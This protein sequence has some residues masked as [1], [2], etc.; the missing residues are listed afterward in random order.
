MNPEAINSVIDNLASKLAI[1]AGKLMEI[2]PR[3]GYK[4][5]APCVILA[6]G[7]CFGICLVIL[8]LYLIS[9]TQDDD[10]CGF[11][12]LGAVI[13]IVCLILSPLFIPDYMLWR[14]DPEAWA[15]DYVIKVL[16]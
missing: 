3:V 1:P 9:H 2:L 11:V 12:F 5:I 13:I 10:Y 8:G 14:Y 6:I 7:S 15:L 4:T 16:R